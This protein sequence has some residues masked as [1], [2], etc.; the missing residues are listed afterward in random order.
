MVVKKKREYRKRKH[1]TSHQREHNVTSVQPS[2]F[3]DIDVLQPDFSSEDDAL[4]PVRI[5]KFKAS[6]QKMQIDSTIKN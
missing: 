1:K 6:F 5:Y 4:S 3:T 2:H